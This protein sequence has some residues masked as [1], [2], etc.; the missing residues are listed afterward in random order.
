MIVCGVDEAGRGPWAGPVVAA[1]VIL[2]AEGAPSG[3]A[4]SKVLTPARRSALEQAIKACCVW[5]IGEASP[6]EID[7]INIRQATHLAMRRAIAGLATPP[8]LALVDGNDAP[9]APC[10]VRPLIGG[11]ALEP[12][13][14]AASIL[15]KVYRDRL[16]VSLCSA[17]PGYGFA[18]HKGYG[19][20]AHAAA[21]RELGP[22]PVHR[23]SFKPVREAAEALTARLQAA[24]HPETDLRPC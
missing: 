12:A 17:Y 11:D 4:D 16:M 8:G 14:S 19:A 21:L 20:P 5:A 6:E 2:P 18:A 1:A 15:A 22:S 3:V 23:M 24:N 13:I 9:K 10:P 7:Q